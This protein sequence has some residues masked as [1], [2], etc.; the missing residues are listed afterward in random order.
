[1]KFTDIHRII[2][3]FI[4][5]I[6]GLTIFRDLQLYFMLLAYIIIA[7]DVVFKA[8]SNIF[9]GNF[10][11][12]TFLMA[13]ASI[14][15][16]IIGSYSEGVAII[17][18]FQV[19]HAFEHY[20]LDK[21]RKSIKS[22]ISLKSEIAHLVKGN[23]IIDVKPTEVN[24]GDIILVKPGERIPLDG[25]V[26]EGFSSLDVSPLTGEAMPLDVSNNSKVLSGSL[27]INSP[28][29]V[30]VAKTYENSTMSRILQMVESANEKKSKNEVF[31]RKFAKY[32]TPIV[33]ASAILLATIPPLF[34]TNVPYSTWIYRA[35]MFL[36][37]SCPCALVVSI[38]LSYF[39]GIGAISKKGVLVKGSIYLENLAKV[40]T[41]V[42]DK[43]GTLTEGKFT[44]NNINNIGIDKKELLN[45][46][47]SVEKLSTH[48]IAKSIVNEYEKV[49]K[50]SNYLEKDFEA[51]NVEEIPG[52]GL[53][54]LV[55]N[56]EV[57]VGNKALL[58]DH[59]IEIGEDTDDVINTLIYVSIDNTFKGIITVGD[60]IKANSKQT[61]KDLRKLGI[62]NLIMLSGDNYLNAKK[63]SEDLD[64]SSF[65]ADLLPED[66]VRE[67]ES[68]IKEGRKV[69]FVGD[70]INDAPSLAIS[71]VGISMGAAGS[72]AAIEASDVVI[73]G[74]ELSSLSSVIT[75]SKITMRIVKE[76]VIFAL[77][78]KFL[79]MIL[80]ALGLVNMWAA[81]FADVGVTFLA[82]LNALRL[83][84]F[85]KNKK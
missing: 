11:D 71:E 67:L 84:R 72:D 22:L 9:K 33:V 53:K 76:N 31:I 56:K 51:L 49:K 24:I 21:S 6:F 55:N 32:Y 34:I 28:I 69:A 8:V 78:V 47:S 79:I 50:E 3:S 59:N 23:D 13:I 64:L 25:T 80:G 15:A 68:I 63:V 57:L 38:P 39:S 73:M 14:G 20:A 26:V 4:L 12:E 54:A 81:V 37:V 77:G 61:I 70:G 30:E 83:L 7:H 46:V 58:E 41:I 48:P 66:K 82:I 42:F 17:L 85:R 29:K 2:L 44:I 19:G 65:K 40:D 52:K 10:L 5:F 60:R 62:T 16:F 36:V 45:Y 18:F 1:M 35:L 43:T 75:L 27:N 74:K